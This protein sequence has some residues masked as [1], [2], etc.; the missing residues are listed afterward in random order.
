MLKDSLRALANSFNDV[1]ECR[2][3][4]LLTE[5]DEE[6]ADAFVSAMASKA[7][8]RAIWAALRSS[9]VAVDRS[10]L[11]RKRGCFRQTQACSCIEKGA[12]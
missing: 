11:D 10:I 1:P 6:T 5:L 3:G 12:D 4:K 2:I 7:S 9:S 8:T